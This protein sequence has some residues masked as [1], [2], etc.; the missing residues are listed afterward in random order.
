MR[1][2]RD[3]L[4][5]ESEST[6]FRPEI[7]EKAI[8]LLS[9]L[10]MLNSHP[11]LKG[12]LALKG[13]TAL[14]LFLLQVPRLS[15]DIDLNYVGSQDRASMEEDRPLLERAIAA[16]C[17][18][19]GYVITRSPSEH[20]GGKFRLQYESAVTPTG[21]LQLDLNFMLRVPLWPVTL[22]DSFPIGSYSA[23]GIP[24]LDVHEITAGKF[25]ALLSRR[26]ARD[27]YD[28]H[29]LLQC[30]LL[31]ANKLRLAF[32]VYGAINRKDWRTVKS[33]DVG[34]DLGDLENQLVPVLRSDALS[35]VA[36]RRTWA[37]S[38]V[39]ECRAGLSAVLPFQSNETEFLDLILDHGD[40]R[41]DL[42]T[43]DHEMQ[44]RISIHPGIL[45]KALNVRQHKTK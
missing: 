45:W 27:L 9:L 31:D 43:A 22:R 4:I 29:R 18:R 12:K 11:Q 32:V 25:A 30:G 14:N 35:H 17:G 21:I 6:G 44:E 7:L 5:A 28:S 39:D 33:D 41:P 20:A 2:S 1:I 42:L 37:Q 38:L 40:V 13:G 36:D 34:F 15:V 23:S 24:M 3:R 8:H 26:A 16:I 10:E 19:E